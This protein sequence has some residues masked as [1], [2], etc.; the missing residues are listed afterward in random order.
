[1]NR[2]ARWTI[3]LMLVLFFARPAAADGV[4]LKIATLAPEGS[5]WMKLFHAWA[6]KVEQ[7][8]EGRVKVKFYSGGVQGDE[9]DV[10]RKIKLGQISGAAVTGIG[11]SSI[12]PETRALELARTYEE[13]DKLRT[14]LGPDIKKAFEA[15]GYVLG[16]WGDVGPVHLFSGKPVKTLDDLRSLKLWLWSDDPVSKQLFTALALHGVPMGVPEVLP[17][18]STGQIDSFFGS[19]LSTLALQWAGHVK[20]MTSIT[21]SEAT[22][23]TVISKAAWD[24][25]SPADQKILEEEAQ[26]MQT[27]VTKQVR[28]DNQRSLDAMK[29]KGLTVTDI[30]PELEKELDKAAEKVARA[31][32]GEVSK[33]FQD[34]VQKLV[35]EYRAKQTARK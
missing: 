5:S 22:G 7:R 29:S 2:L 4:V 34:K 30:S 14:L 12:A 19:P 20:Y 15:K 33:E 6:Q 1:M 25:I 24:K 8:T 27:L 11:L 16:G 17:G 10:L 21:L 35:D 31:N 9:R 28:E 26:A 18:L 3:S 23:A 32:A 13:L